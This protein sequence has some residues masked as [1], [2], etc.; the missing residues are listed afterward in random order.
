MMIDYAN[1]EQVFGPMSPFPYNR[2]V[3]LSIETARRSLE[4]SLFIDRILKTL[5]LEQVAKSYPPKNENGLRQLHQQLCDNTS[6]NLH[7]KLSIIYY[8]LLDIDARSGDVEGRAAAFATLAGVPDSYRIFMKGLWLMDTRNFELALERLTHPSLNADFADEIIIALARHAKDG[9]YSLPLAYYHTVQPSLRSSEAVQALFDA[10]ARCS[11]IEAFEFSRSHADYMRRPLFQRLVSAVLDPTTQP[12]GE[13]TADR[14]HELASLPLDADEEQ[15]FL[16]YLERGE[17]KRL[18][19][20]KDTLI[21]RRIAT[22]QGVPT[23]DKGGW[24]TVLGGF[25]TGSGGRTL[26]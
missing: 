12:G 7:H 15:W 17:G 22:G 9:D 21:M 16:D 13:E 8:L 1:F 18:R 11:V 5:N 2:T 26:V 24:A 23:S 25:K 14:A 19:A 6:M 20:A 4:G 10:T 3:T